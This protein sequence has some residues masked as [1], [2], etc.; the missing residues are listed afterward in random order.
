VPAAFYMFTRFTGKEQQLL[1]QLLITG[2][3]ALN[4]ALVCLC[5]LLNLALVTGVQLD[6]A[7]AAL[8]VEG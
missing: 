3:C 4:G 1:R 5:L 7:E 8:V 6:D 2:R